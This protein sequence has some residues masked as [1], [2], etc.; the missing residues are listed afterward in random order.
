[1][2]SEEVTFGLTPRAR[3]LRFSS[4][5]Y[6]YVPRLLTKGAVEATKLIIEGKLTEMSSEPR[7]VQVEVKE[8]DGGKTLTARLSKLS[9]TRRRRSRDDEPVVISDYPGGGKG[10]TL[11]P[12]RM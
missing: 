2:T 12:M 9:A 6:R 4:C 8:G 3:R 5:A 11:L 10:R 1:M 7:N